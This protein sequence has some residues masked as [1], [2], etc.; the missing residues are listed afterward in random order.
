MFELVELDPATGA[1]DQ[2]LSIR[3]GTWAQCKRHMDEVFA[4]FAEEWD[5][6]WSGLWPCLM[7]RP[8]E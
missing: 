4:E 6:G 1:E 5:E 8:A 7:I 2:T 3:P